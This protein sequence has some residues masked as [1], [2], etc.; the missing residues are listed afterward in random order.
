MEKV[1]IKISVDST[2]VDEL[3]E[4]LKIAN[5]LADELANKN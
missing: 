4:K 2:E 1:N 3:I 5:S